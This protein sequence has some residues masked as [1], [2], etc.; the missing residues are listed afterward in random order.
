M[1][2]RL[3]YLLS[4]LFVLVF[5]AGIRAQCPPT[6][7]QQPPAAEIICVGAA[8]TFSV[9]AT[10]NA[11]LTYQWR[12]N[13]VNVSAANITGGT[14]AA[15]TISNVGAADAGAY[16]VVITASG[17]GTTTTSTV[18]AVSIPA[19]FN[20]GSHNTNAITACS[21]YDPAPL[22]FNPPNIAPSGGLSPYTYQWQLSTNGGTTWNNISGETT[23]SYD[24]TNLITPGTYSYR[25]LV[26][27]ACGTQLPTA[28]KTITI[29][30][31][32]TVVIAGGTSFEPHPPHIHLLLLLQERTT[33]K[34]WLR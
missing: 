4:I 27:D 30:A 2:G 31:D 28:S 17:C 15:I 13:G 1:R 18:T 26:T 25:A 11:P 34:Y 16:D 7:T 21:N 8:T 3:G 10:G 12:K 23:A 29:V 5:S 9:T 32:P 22:N 6:I 24:P 20:P 14:T 19:T 33:T